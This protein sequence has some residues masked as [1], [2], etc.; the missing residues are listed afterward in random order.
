MHEMHIKKCSPGW[1]NHTL[2]WRSWLA[3]LH[4]KKE[5]KEGFEEAL[6]WSFKHVQIH[7]E[8][9]KIKYEISGMILGDWL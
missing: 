8:L 6:E 7:G 9:T 4:E 3:S 5:N 2:N 1:L